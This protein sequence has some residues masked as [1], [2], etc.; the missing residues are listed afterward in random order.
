M[1]YTFSFKKHK[2]QTYYFYGSWYNFKIVTYK[3]KVF[4]L[5]QT[6]QKLKVFNLIQTKQKSN[7]QT[8]DDHFYF[9]SF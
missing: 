8:E 3:L 5:I 4:Y 1:W 7:K 9:L 2:V 6:K